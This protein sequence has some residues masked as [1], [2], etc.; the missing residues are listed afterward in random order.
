MP[1]LDYYDLLGVPEDATPEEIRHA[2]RDAALR[3]H[4]DVN[5]EKSA[6]EQFILIQAAFKKLSEPTSRTEYD[7]LLKIERNDPVT[8]EILYSRSSLTEIDEPQLLYTMLEFSAADQISAGLSPP[9]NICL[10]LDHSTSMQGE[11]MDTVKTAAIELIKQLRHDDLLSIVV[12]SDR[13]EVLLQAGQRQDH[14]SLES[15]IRLV[16]PEGG[17]EIF[18][19][20]EA[21]FEE[22]RRFASR[23][24][25]NH[26]ILLTD[27]RT[28]GDE[29]DCLRLAS[30]AAM[31]GIR[32]TGMG[33]GAEWNDH[34]L[35]ELAGR[36]G[37]TSVYISR[38]KDIQKFL[39]EK[40]DSLKNVFVERVI[41]SLETSPGVELTSIF[42]LQP[43]AGIMPTTQP[44][45]LGSIPLNEKLSILLEFLVPPIPVN[46]S[47]YQLATI[48]V[49]MAIPAHPYGSFHTSRRI[50][51]LVTTN[52]AP[53]MP[54][55]PIYKALSRITLYR[56][57]ERARRDVSEGK[58]DEASL[59]LQRLA[60]QFLNQGEKELAKTT[61][62]EAER[63]HITHLFSA[64]GE[65]AI[66]Y[67]T[68]S[69]LLPANV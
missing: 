6:T 65:K 17:T 62:M 57:Q 51:R 64:E 43:D 45:H 18:Q 28:Y 19:G 46:P 4:P 59:R 48:G 2:F 69:L 30:K 54:P 68:R 27:G 37:G 60:T 44:I 7:A 11:R 63:I 67:G 56:M 24:T 22:I 36:T 26:I 3:L 42:R 10:V 58:P 49:Q 38:A 13:A 23:A 52:A 33:V 47:R 41:L 9:I 29:A 40:F 25:V 16:R 5:P 61:L 20:L 15:Q 34:F 21:G 12:F 50:T 35:D 53:E 31:Q 8:T 1:A 32:I 39:Q 55:R 66:K 14:N